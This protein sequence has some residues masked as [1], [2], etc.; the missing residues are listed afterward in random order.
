ML[1]YWHGTPSEKAFAQIARERV[2]RPLSDPYGKYQGSNS[3]PMAGRVY[4]SKD[5]NYALI[6]A[7]GGDYAGDVF[8]IKES[9]YGCLFEV[10]VPV[11]AD[12]VIDEDEL[13]ELAATGSIDWLSDLGRD[14]CEGKEYGPKLD[15]IPLWDA[16]TYEYYDAWITLGHLLHGRLSPTD[17]RRLLKYAK[18]YAVSGDVRVVHGYRIDKARAS[19]M[20]RG[21][22][23]STFR[24]SEKLF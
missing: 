24:V 6:Y 3:T 13:G 14:L 10:K 17:M 8:E 16:V 23:E 15:R 21:D 12:I 22:I 7:L 5:P 1:R 11:G 19:E 20:K 9:R 18:N 2:L 4:V